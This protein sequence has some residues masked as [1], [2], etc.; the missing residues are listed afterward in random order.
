VRCPSNCAP[1]LSADGR[2]L[3][4]AVNTPPAAGARQSGFRA[5][6]GSVAPATALR[7]ALTDAVSGT[8]AW[9]SHNTASSPA[10][11]PDGDVK[12]RCLNTIAVDPLTRSIL[13]NNEDGLLL[14][15]DLPSCQ[16]V[17]SIALTGD[18][19]ASYTPIA[20]GP[21]GAIHAINNAVLFSIGR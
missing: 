5:A 20:I 1:A 13:I 4:V 16:F 7:I 9:V 6:L 19:A 12:Q 14:C 18:L 15:R 10:I 11:G 3:Y 8:P 2:T 17:E 21:D